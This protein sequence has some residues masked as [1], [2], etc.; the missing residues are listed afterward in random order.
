MEF[1]ARGSY[2]LHVEHEDMY[3]VVGI[4]KNCVHEGEWE[5]RVLYTS[6]GVNIEFGYEGGALP[7]YSRCL[8]NFLDGTFKQVH[9]VEM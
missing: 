9:P 3:V 5:G 4:V 1:P 6:F 2:W 8:E 7:Y